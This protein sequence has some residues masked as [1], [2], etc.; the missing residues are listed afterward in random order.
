MRIVVNLV[1]LAMIG[2]GVINSYFFIFESHLR[3]SLLAAVMGIVVGAFILIAE[4]T[5]R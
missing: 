2:L 3:L 1:A 4:N 5:N